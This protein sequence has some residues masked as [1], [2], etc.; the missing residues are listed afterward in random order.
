MKVILYI[1]IALIFFTSC[2]DMTQ[3]INWNTKNIPSKAVVEGQIVTEYRFQKIILSKTADYFLDEQTPR[4]SG[5]LVTV[6]DG[7][8]TYY[9][10]EADTAKGVY[11]STEMFA[12]IAGRTYTLNVTLPE[13]LNG[14]STINAKDEIIQGFSIDSMNVY[15][16]KNPFAAFTEEAD[17]DTTI[18]V[19]YMKGNQPKD[20]INYYLIQVYKSGVPV[21]KNITEMGMLS[22]EYSEDPQETELFY[23]YMGKFTVGDTLS[24]EVIS[25]SKQYYEYIRT[26]GELNTPPDPL[27]FSGPPADAIGNI[28]DGKQLGYFSAGQITRFTAIAQKAENIKEA[29]N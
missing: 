24:I 29:V 21:Y 7:T 12:G 28:N 3:E 23:Y 11:Y 18:T 13:S 22:D 25:I 1:T 10:D 17:Q 4:I 5:A 15:I 26:L 8:T 14:T 19:F 20:I 6:S 9:F 2:Q 16:F 27:G